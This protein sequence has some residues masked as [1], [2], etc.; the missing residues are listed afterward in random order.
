[1]EMHSC[2]K[3]R[4]KL[5]KPEEFENAG[6]SYE[7]GGLLILLLKRLKSHKEGGHEELLQGKRNENEAPAVSE[8]RLRSYN[9]RE[10]L[11]FPF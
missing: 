3:E 2:S 11:I 1:M 6:M 9:V 8:D 4:K 7:D 5:K 10:A